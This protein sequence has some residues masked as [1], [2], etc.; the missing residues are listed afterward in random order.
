[1]PTNKTVIVVRI[2]F[3]LL[4]LC[5]IFGLIRETVSTPALGNDGGTHQASSYAPVGAF[6]GLET[7]TSPACDQRRSYFYGL[8]RVGPPGMGFY[9]GPGGEPGHR[10]FGMD[11]S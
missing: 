5:A 7:A 6:I 2:V 8:R 4:I 3:A 1:M 9:S 10:F 11:R